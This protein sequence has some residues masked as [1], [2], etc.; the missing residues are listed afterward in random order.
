MS[1]A[2]ARARLVRIVEDVLPTTN[3]LVGEG[4]RFVHLPEGRAGIQCRSRSFWLEANTDGDGGITGP[5]TPD[6]Q[7]QPRQTF[8]LTLTVSYKL[9]ERRADLD[10]LLAAD[11]LAI[12]KDL[13]SQGNWAGASSGIMSLTTDPLFL[14]TRRV[15][16]AES[17]EMRMGMTLLFR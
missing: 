15:V 17:V 9:Y 12:S 3:L 11:Q 1:Y 5:Y 6:I 7:G 16:G 13:L 14:P 2:T 4:C 8:P 10:V